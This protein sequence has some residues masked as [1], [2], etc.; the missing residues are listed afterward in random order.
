MLVNGSDWTRGPVEAGAIDE[1][2]REHFA[3]YA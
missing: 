3:E 1:H 2:N